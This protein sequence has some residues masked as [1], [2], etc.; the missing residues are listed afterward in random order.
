MTNVR[1]ELINHGE[2]DIAKETVLA[3]NLN[4]NDIRDIRNRGG[5][6]SKT[7]ML[8]GTN[9]NNDILGNIFNV[10]V[11]MLTF[12]QNIREAVR[13]IVDGFVAA[14]GILQIRKVRKVFKNSEDFHI[15]YDAYIKSDV[16]SFYNDIS[17]KYLNQIDLSEF[18][19]T[20]TKDIVKDSMTGGT[21]T[22]GYAYFLAYNAD[23]YA[24]Y[25]PRDFL[26]AVYAKTYWDRIISEAGYTYEWE[27]LGELKFDKMIIPYNGEQYQPLDDSLFSLKASIGAQSYTYPFWA[28]TQ[29]GSIGQPSSTLIWDV[30]EDPNDRYDNLTGKIDV[31]DYTGELTVSFSYFANMNIFLFNSTPHTPPSDIAPDG[32]FAAEVRQRCV[33]RDSNGNLVGVVMDEVIDNIDSTSLAGGYSMG[34]TLVSATEYSGEVIF[35]SEQFPNTTTLEI[36]VYTNVTNLNSFN[37]Y[38]SNTSGL[39]YNVNVNFTFPQ[40]NVEI[41]YITTESDSYI[42][43]GSYIDMNKIIP[44]KIKQSDFILSIIKMFNL[45]IVQDKYDNSKLI[46]KTRD[47]FYADGAE[48][49]WT[50]KLDIKSVDIEPISNKQKKI[51]TFTYKDDSKDNILKKYQDVTNEN[52][53]QLQYVFENQFI[54]DIETVEPIFSPTVMLNGYRYGQNNQLPYINSRNPK[55]NLRILYLGDVLDG[56]FTFYDVSTGIGDYQSKYRYAGHLY[57]NALEPNRDLNFGVCDFYAH[58]YN[59]L[60]N[61]NLFNNYYRTQMNIFD[62]GHILTAYFDLNYVDVANL[63]LNERIYVYDSW[64]NINKIIDFQINNKMLTKVELISSDKTIGDFFPRNTSFQVTKRY[65]NEINAEVNR[66]N[67]EDNSQNTYGKVTNVEVLGKGNV[68]QPYSTNVL[69]I[70]DN[71]QIDGNNTFVNGNNNYVAG[72]NINVIGLNG[73]YYD[74]SNKT[75]TSTFV[76]VSN[77]ISAGRD[78]VLNIYPDNKIINFIDAGR[79]EVRPLGTYSIETNIDAARNR[80]I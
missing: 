5:A 47:K 14:E 45:Y 32:S 80:I 13:I 38:Y 18:N 68:I 37:G 3:I 79:D 66:Q 70:G 72:D 39:Y 78:N 69:T 7:I 77:F 36:E 1:L 33:A 67:K 17:G 65:S 76:R 52:Y 8:P 12:N 10:N 50:D 44:K 71:N 58:R 29:T 75:Y 54:K 74:E 25:E 48:L 21:I 46:V 23:Q 26:P 41:G 4:L 40:Q 22:D 11:Q 24:N 9:N 49:D 55:N 51:T 6:W 35:L 61:N 62:T 15:E 56:Y 42:G 34:T 2:L 60:T 31:T 30:E 28:V 57:P 27:E 53:G 20:H 43:E 73:G 59:S 63:E 19:H 64:W 16:S